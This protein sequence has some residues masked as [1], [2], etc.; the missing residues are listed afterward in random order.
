[1]T[2]RQ[3]VNLGRPPTS[4]PLTRLAAAGGA[5]GHPG[6][7]RGVAGDRTG[8]ERL[9]PSPDDGAKKMARRTKP[10]SS[11]LAPPG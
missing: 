7:R 6:K 1:M 11:F 2:R 3:E 9:D 10:R 8:H 4:H 5:S